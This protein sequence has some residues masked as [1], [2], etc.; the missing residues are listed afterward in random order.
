MNR[1][2]S[3]FNAGLAGAAVL[4]MTA[5]LWVGWI[6]LGWRWPVIQASLPAFHGPLMVGGFL[7][8]LISLERAVA[9]KKW[10]AYLAPVLCAFSGF[11][12]ILGTPAV[13]PTLASVFL[14]L[15]SAGLLVVYFY[16]VRLQRTWS[17]LVMTI[18][19]LCW[20]VGNLLWLAGTP[21][22]R[23]VLWW[24]SFLILTIGAER[25]ELGRLVRLTQ[26]QEMWFLSGTA[27]LIIG[28]TASLVWFQTGTRLVGISLIW[29]A[30]WLWQHDL[31]RR[32]I[33]TS[34]LPRFAAACLLSGYVWLGIAGI[35]C[36]IAGNPAAGTRYDALLHMIFLG[37]V[38][39]M[40]FGHAPIIF[41]AVLNRQIHFQ[42]ILYLPLVLLHA[43]LALRVLADLFLWQ[44]G[45]LWGGL[46]NGLAILTFFGLL[47][48]SQ[49]GLLHAPEVEKA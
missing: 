31:A 7:G 41:P 33:R 19:A 47:L 5:G 48:V 45:R 43:S 4:S 2:I 30:F 1:G 9:V 29:L 46:L 18:G 3:R 28:L 39:S 16:I 24:A 36:V 25:L 37:F 23:L 8:T 6:R 15:G 10:W 35:W 42:P 12:M 11:A 44:N 27:L 34:G 26:R 14:T 17:N 38:I 40:I 13:H 32:T 49:P 21:I 20:L 22:Y